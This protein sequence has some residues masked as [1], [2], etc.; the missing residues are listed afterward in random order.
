MELLKKGDKMYL[1][2][3]MSISNGS[4]DV[5]GGLATIKEIKIDER[6]G[7]DHF[8]GIFVKFEEVPDHSYN[9]KSL[10]AD[11]EKLSKL[12][13]GKVAHPDPD[14]DRPWIEEGDIVDGKVYHGPDIW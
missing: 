13:E 9:Y 6:L 12:Y 1:R 2:G 10:M 5:S 11:Q 7:A 8:N 14:I 4:S 3:S